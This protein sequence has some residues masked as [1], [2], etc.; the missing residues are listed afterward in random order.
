MTWDEFKRR[1]EEGFMS[2]I[3]KSTLLR[4]FTELVHG[5]MTL[6][7]SVLDLR[8]YQDTD[9]LRLIWLSKEMRSSSVD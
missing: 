1:F 6:L 9:T 5:D 8:S 4:R 2:K 3:A 7:E